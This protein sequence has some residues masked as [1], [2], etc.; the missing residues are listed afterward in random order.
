MSDKNEQKIT[1]S[2]E[3]C[4]KRLDKFLSEQFSDISRSKLHALIEGGQVLVNDKPSKPSHHL[5]IGETIDVTIH[6]RKN[7]LKPYDFAVKI[8][9]EDDDILV[10]DKPANLVVHPPQEGYHQ[11][12]VNA[13]IGMKKDL[14]TV[15][16][17]RPGIVHRLDKETSGLLVVAKNNQA[18]LALVEIFRS[19]N[20][21]KEYRAIVWGLMKKD[22]MA[23][24]LP[25]A[26]DA[27]NRL[28]MK[29]SFLK[30]KEALTELD[31][32]ERLEDATH[33]SVKIHTGRMHQ[34]RV[35][36]NFLGYPIVGDKKY[37]KKD[38]YEDL[39][40]HAYK[41]SFKHPI[42]KKQLEFTSKVPKYFDK[43]IEENK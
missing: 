30:S 17:D 1:V 25:V 4:G 32:L 12:L 14:S 13:L 40:L 9:Y 35:H 5:K 42:T 2:Q 33:L 27:K 36:L 21:S 18:H 22:H 20:I 8:I 16:S 41:L 26:R 11:T 15:S 7:E 37:G 43:F 3:A 28:K 23:V 24:D 19:R 29:V 6:K 10:V 38:K 34:I 39:F 31:V